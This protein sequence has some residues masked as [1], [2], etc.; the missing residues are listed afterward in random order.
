MTQN[1]ERDLYVN[2]LITEFVEAI[3]ELAKANRK[4][5]LWDHIRF[6]ECKK[7]FPQVNA[8]LVY[9]S[10]KNSRH[11]VEERAVQRKILDKVLQKLLLNAT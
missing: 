3:C 5:G 10:E 4:T 9:L 11:N 6:E 7:P 1:T 8:E 2:Q